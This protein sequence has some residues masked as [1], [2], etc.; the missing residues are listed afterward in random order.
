MTLHTTAIMALTLGLT[1]LAPQG[2]CGTF[3]DHASVARSG[4][5][6]IIA[7][8]LDDEG[9]GYTVLRLWGSYYE[10]GYAHCELLGDEVVRA[11]TEVKAYADYL[12]HDWDFLRSVIAPVLRARSTMG[13]TS[14]SSPGSFGTRCRRF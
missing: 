5:G 13:S 10:M 12:G 14:R 3:G 9:R 4:H 1:S 6:E 7:Q 2:Q 11:V 8:E